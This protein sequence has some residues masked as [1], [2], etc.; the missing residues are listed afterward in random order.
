M[1]ELLSPSGP[2]SGRAIGATQEQREH[3]RF[4]IEGAT[5]VLGKGGFLSSLGFDPKKNAIVNLSKGGIVVLVGKRVPPDTRVHVRIEISKPADVVESE[6]LVRWC[7]QSAKSDAQ[8]YVGIR[9]ERL[10]PL[11]QKKIAL[12]REWFTSEEYRAKV[13]IRNRLLHASSTD[14]SFQVINDP[15]IRPL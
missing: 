6:G 14:Q 5:A 3:P 13:S 10:D 12:M 2:A 11:S 8:F 9:F 1:R 15:N 7:G 4:K